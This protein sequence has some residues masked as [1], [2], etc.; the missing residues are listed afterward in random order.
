MRVSSAFRVLGPV[1]WLASACVTPESTEM[2]KRMELTLT[3]ARTGDDAPVVAIQLVAVGGK[4]QLVIATEPLGQ[5]PSLEMTELGAA[6]LH[7]NPLTSLGG[8]F[9]LP[10]WS[11]REESDGSFS[12]VSTN[13]GGIF[14][15]LSSKNTRAPEETPVS[16][17]HPAGVFRRPR[18]VKADTTPAAPL[19]AISAEDRGPRLVLFAQER[20]HAYG[21]FTPLPSPC[22]GIPEDALLLRRRGGYVLLAKVDVPDGSGTVVCRT[23]A[24]GETPTLGVLCGLELDASFRAVG[25]PFQPFDAL[26]VFEFDADVSGEGIAVFATTKAGAALALGKPAGKVFRREKLAGVRSEA[27][28]V[29]PTLAAVGGRNW[30]AAIR[31]PRTE[32]A[33]IVWGSQ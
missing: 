16:G 19:T 33:T 24:R 27:P 7:R 4:P 30:V 13:A 17:A 21:A 18:F 26:R 2:G 6:E 31:A 12:I 1:A 22:A 10:S 5:E 3:P 29:N 11:V 8:R 14:S 25:E 23:D 9:Y 15:P 32:Q 20:Q 28:L